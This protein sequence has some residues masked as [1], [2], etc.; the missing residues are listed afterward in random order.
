MLVALVGLPVIARAKYKY[1]KGNRVIP[2]VLIHPPKKENPSDPDPDPIPISSRHLGIRSSEVQLSIERPPSKQENVDEQMNPDQ[3]QDLVDK[4]LKSNF[5]KGLVES[6]WC[7]LILVFLAA[8]T[9]FLAA[10]SIHSAPLLKL[11]FPPLC[12]FVFPSLIVPTLFFLRQ[13]KA[14]RTLLELID[15]H[16]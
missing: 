14:F 15:Q 3:G 12:A 13:P 6:I 5:I 4:R 9:V 11:I 2:L 7:V 1:R 8:P 10:N 16:Y